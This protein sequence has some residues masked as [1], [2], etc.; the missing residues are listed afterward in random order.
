MT[1]G[2]FDY[3]QKLWLKRNANDLAI[4]RAAELMETVGIG[5]L[6]C[7]VTAVAGQLVTVKWRIDTAPWTLPKVTIPCAGQSPWNYRPTQ[8]GDTGLAVPAAVL[9]GEIVGTS[10]T[11][12]TFRPPGNLSALYFIPVG[13]KAFTPADANA[14][15]QQG[16]N[17]F[18][19]QTTE[20]A[21]ASSIVTNQ[22]GTTITYG[23]DTVTLDSSGLSATIGSTSV[24]ATSSQ[25]KLTAGG[26]TLQIDSSG[27]TL[28]GKVFETHTH[29]GVTTGSGDTGPPV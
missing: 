24:T 27:I 23:S 20:G 29:S 15:I 22:N 4:R 28:D 19:G 17:G 10:S 11:T 9:L 14:A 26:V 25:I 13:T 7:E 2:P 5:G 18:I 8:V 1:V 16:P 12:P 21:N 3:F 6:P